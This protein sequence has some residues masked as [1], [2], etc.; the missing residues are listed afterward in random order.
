MGVRNR[1]I[2]ADASLPGR[3]IGSQSRAESEYCVYPYAWLCGAN[4]LVLLHLLHIRAGETLRQLPVPRRFRFFVAALFRI[5]IS[6]R[7][8][9]N[10][11]YCI[12]VPLKS[13]DTRRDIVMLI[14]RCLAFYIAAR[15][16]VIR[17][18][19]LCI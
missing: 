2:D 9:V 12:V 3:T 15:V 13:H 5:S 14:I 16:S 10:V 6:V 4:N 18:H 11:A 7:V 1:D 19:I 8:N 17:L